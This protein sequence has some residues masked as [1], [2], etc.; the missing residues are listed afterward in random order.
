MYNACICIYMHVHVHIHTHTCA[1]NYIYNAIVAVKLG[2][3]KN[4]DLYTILSYNY[5]IN[6]ITIMFYQEKNETYNEA[7]AKIKLPLLDQ[8]IPL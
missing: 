2:F 3:F 8:T 5:I 7:V 1:C 6:N 4:I